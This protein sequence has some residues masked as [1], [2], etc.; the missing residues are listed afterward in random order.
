MEKCMNDVLHTADGT[1]LKV[2][3]KNV[4]TDLGF[5]HLLYPLH[6]P[7]GHRQMVWGFGV[8]PSMHSVKG[9]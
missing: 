1:I 6:P 8:D 7:Q 2:D 5:I 4:F 9:S 3:H